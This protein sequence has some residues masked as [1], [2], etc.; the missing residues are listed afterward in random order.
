MFENVSFCMEIAKSPKIGRIYEMSN[1]IFVLIF[2]VKIQILVDVNVVRF[3]RILM[4]K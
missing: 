1:F 3:A 4:E 2:G